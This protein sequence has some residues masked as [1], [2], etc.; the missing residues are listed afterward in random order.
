MPVYFVA[1]DEDPA[2][3]AAQPNTPERVKADYV[4]AAEE[5][6]AIYLDEPEA[7]VRGKSTLW[8]VP[9]YLYS[10][11]TEGRRDGK[12]WRSRGLPYP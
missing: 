3:I 2:P 12:E 8:L 4:L 9:E 11:N 10:L 7:Q 1:G 5:H 6:G